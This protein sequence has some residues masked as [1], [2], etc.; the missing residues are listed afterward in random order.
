MKRSQLILIAI[1]VIAI[2]G[3]YVLPTVVVDNE[4]K[5]DG[6]SQE[7]S[8]SSTQS[9]D[10][11]AMHEAELSTD[12]R[13]QLNTLKLQIAEN[14]SK[15]EVKS[16]TEEIAAIYQELGKYDS[17]G[18]YL[19]LT[20]DKQSDM[21]LA[22]KAG[23]AYYEAF[24]FALDPEKVTYTAEQTRKYLNK[25][26]ENDPTRL[27]LKTKVAM[28]Y[29]SSSNPMQGITMMREIL[30]EDPQNEDGLFNMGVL[31]MQSGQYKRATER[32]EELIQYHPDNLQGQF[33]LGVSYF[34]AKQN[35]KAKAQFEKVK[36]MTKD[37]MILGSIESYL[38]K[39]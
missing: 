18:Y 8:S 23:N 5:A 30:E 13:L 38:E 3:L 1:G 20:A 28:T 9:T 35:N 39:L 29:V 27:D 6:I 12:Q 25:V 15:E 24:S 16:S 32:F 26:L 4:S 22:E 33:Y 14:S 10:P 19:S 11:V 7:N 37:E 21:E 2:A 34:E 17:A 31:S 36:T